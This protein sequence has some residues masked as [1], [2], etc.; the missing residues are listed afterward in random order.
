[1]KNTVSAFLGLI[2]ALNFSLQA[3]EHSQHKVSIT[4]NVGISLVGSLI[5]LSDLD[6]EARYTTKVLPAGQLGA[7]FFVTHW[8]SMGI[9]GSYQYM[10]INYTDYGENNIDFSTNI[11]R[12]NVAFRPL[13]HYLNK[14]NIN[15]Y[16]GLRLGMTYWDISTT[17]TVE[18]YEPADYLSFSSGALFAPQ[19]VAFGIR[20]YFTDFLGANLEFAVGAP[21]Y[22]SGGISLRF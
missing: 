12:I 5:D 22:V 3:Q 20:G 7:D 2:L 13:F 14:G 8:L 9:A 15:M 16:S 17:E 10:Q 6:V 19:L 21:H 4:G 1:M 11:D 18:N